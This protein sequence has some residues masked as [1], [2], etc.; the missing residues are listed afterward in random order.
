MVVGPK[1]LKWYDIETKSPDFD[2][3]TNKVELITR[4][5][6]HNR[7]QSLKYL[8]KCRVQQMQSFQ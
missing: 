5:L 1:N 2:S 8:R 3:A 6:R 7:R 4:K